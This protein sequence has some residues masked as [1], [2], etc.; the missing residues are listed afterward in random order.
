LDSNSGWEKISTKENLSQNFITIELSD[1]DTGD[2]D[3]T[4]NGSVIHLGG[5]SATSSFHEG[6]ESINCFIQTIKEVTNIT[7]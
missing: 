3:Q 5:I 6:L 7:Y 2:L 1:G 4:I